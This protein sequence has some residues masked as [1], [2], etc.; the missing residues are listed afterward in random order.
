MI[1]PCCSCCCSRVQN[2][3]VAISAS[4]L[5]DLANIASKRATVIYAAM[6]E[7]LRVAD[8]AYRKVGG[9][10]VCILPLLEVGKEGICQT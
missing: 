7:A 9:G 8:T 10:Y 5:I 4:E 6:T 1:C 2:G 3:G